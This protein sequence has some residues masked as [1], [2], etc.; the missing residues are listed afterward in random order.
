MRAAI[1]RSDLILLVADKNIEFA[2]RGTL[3]RHQ[4]LNIR[5]PRFVIYVHPERDPGCLR[6]ANTFLRPHGS[7]YQHALVVFDRSGCGKDDL[8]RAALEREVEQALTN[9]GWAA[10][11]CAIVVDP[12]LENWVWGD[13]PRVDQVLGWAGRLP[14]RAWLRQNGYCAAMEKPARPKEAMEAALRVVGKA[15]SASVFRAL[16][17]SVSLE[18]CT[19]PAFAKLR[20][21][22]RAWFPVSRNRPATSGA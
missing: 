2:M 10:R 22:L 7:A 4:A 11:A 8:P 12:E 20:R 17:E 13:S 5:S 1:V 21:T 19:D 16:A 18:R 9:A 3:A 15:R 6:K 14:L